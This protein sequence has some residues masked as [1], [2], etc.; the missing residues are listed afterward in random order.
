MVNF[1]KKNHRNWGSTLLT[2]P[3]LLSFP[4]LIL[5]TSSPPYSQYLLS[6]NHS[7]LMPAIPADPSVQQ[8]SGPSLSISLF[9]NSKR[10][11]LLNL[12]FT[13]SHPNHMLADQAHRKSHPW[14][15]H[16]SLAQSAMATKLMWYANH[17]HCP[18]SRAWEHG[19]QWSA[20]LVHIPKV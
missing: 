14:I 1:L 18:L 8:Y 6:Y 20:A 11:I 16:P 9:W 10:G 2:V 15:R 17:S 3:Q 5:L 12:Y 13:T 19:W 4:V 7:L